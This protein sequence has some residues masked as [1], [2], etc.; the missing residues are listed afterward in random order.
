[1]ESGC[2]HEIDDSVQLRIFN[3]FCYFATSILN[4]KIAIINKY[5]MKLRE[6]YGEL[7]DYAHLKSEVEVAYSSEEC[8][9]KSVYNTYAFTEILWF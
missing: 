5:L 4:I 8:S 1:M 2:I 3:F 9:T 7:F 6:A